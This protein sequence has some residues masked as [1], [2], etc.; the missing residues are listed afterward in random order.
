MSFLKAVGLFNVYF[1]SKNDHLSSSLHFSLGTWIVI[2][3][4]F[5]HEYVIGE[6]SQNSYYKQTLIG[7]QCS[8]ILTLSSSA[9]YKAW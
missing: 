4:Y 3:S 7:K 1:L 2:L 6:T 8:A 9:K 5:T